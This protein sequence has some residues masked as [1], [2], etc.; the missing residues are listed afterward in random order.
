[1]KI[2]SSL[3]LHPRSPSLLSFHLVKINSR[4]SG[5]G[6]SW[7]FGTAVCLM[8]DVA[9]PGGQNVI[10]NSREE[11]IVG[12]ERKIW[13]VETNVVFCSF[14]GCNQSQICLAGSPKCFAAVVYTFQVLLVRGINKAKVSFPDV[15][16]EPHKACLTFQESPKIG[17]T[18]QSEC[19]HIQTDPESLFHSKV[20]NK[21][22]GIWLKR[23]WLS[24][25][26]A[27]CCHFF[28][29]NSL[30]WEDQ[31]KNKK[32]SSVEFSYLSSYEYIKGFL[33]SDMLQM[34]REHL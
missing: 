17:A 30:R 23:S 2:P 31:S 7:S 27:H 11:D 19:D 15:S 6:G 4:G 13:K 24:P 20:P 14:K 3:L 22:V 16:A 8:S 18:S 33:T 21:H 32:C 9:T 5:E 25:Q 28:Q 34:I 12:W 10:M 1:M 29:G 26:G